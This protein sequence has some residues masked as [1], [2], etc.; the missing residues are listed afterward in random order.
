MLEPIEKLTKHSTN[1]TSSSTQSTD[2]YFYYYENYYMRNPEEIQIFDKSAGN[3]RL[4]RFD[5]ECSDNTTSGDEYNDYDNV[6]EYKTQNISHRTSDR[7]MLPHNTN[8][9]VNKCAFIVDN[10]LSSSRLKLE[11]T[12]ANHQFNKSFSYANNN[13]N[14]NNH[15]HNHNNINNNTN[16]LFDTYQTH[17]KYMN[18]EELKEQKQQQQQQENSS[19]EYIAKRNYNKQ[20][21]N[22]NIISTTNT[23]TEDFLATKQTRNDEIKLGN[24]NSLRKIFLN[25]TTTSTDYLLHQTKRKAIQMLNTYQAAE[26]ECN[27]VHHTTSNDYAVLKPIKFVADEIEVDLAHIEPGS[28]IDFVEQSTHVLENKPSMIQ[29]VGDAQAT[30][31]ITDTFMLIKSCLVCMLYFVPGVNFEGS[32]FQCF[33]RRQGTSKINGSDKAYFKSKI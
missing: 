26:S 9:P 30:N 28:D 24:V 6:V 33:D 16:L 17:T 5:A 23:I 10:M 29:V 21:S 2:D 14:K 25:S 18:T 31:T 13:N 22:I 15:T 7:N 12:T 8:K 3:T 1:R 11:E 19:S 4:I 32:I 20:K 27:A